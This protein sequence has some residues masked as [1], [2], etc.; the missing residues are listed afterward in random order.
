MQVKESNTV[1]HGAMESAMHMTDGL[2]SHP[3]FKAALSRWQRHSGCDS[4]FLELAEYAVLADQLYQ[5]G[6]DKHQDCPGI[7]D[8]EVSCPFGGWFCEQ[9]DENGNTTR[10][11]LAEAE[12]RKMAQEFWAQ[13]DREH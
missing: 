11:S 7:F 10:H 3:D 12:L 4:L 5:E 8:Y 1:P 2:V 13:F 9:I 6:F